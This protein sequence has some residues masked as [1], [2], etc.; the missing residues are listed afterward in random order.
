LRAIGGAIPSDERADRSTLSDARFL[1]R[2]IID[3]IIEIESLCVWVTFLEK[4]ASL[5]EKN[6][7]PRRYDPKLLRQP[8]SRPALVR[9]P[10]PLDR[11][12]ATSST[13][14]TALI[15]AIHDPGRILADPTR[16]ERATFAFGGRRSIQLSYGSRSTHI[17]ANAAVRKPRP[18]G[19]DQNCFSSRSM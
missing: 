8:A 14:R 6:G 4:L 1:P 12:E 3:R 13:R 10:S 2:K 11:D 16:F 5:G 18:I 15:L 7:R 9:H 19:T 17:A